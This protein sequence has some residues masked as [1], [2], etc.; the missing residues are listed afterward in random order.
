M[1]LI[2]R[3]DQL[4]IL[5]EYLGDAVAGSGRLVLLGG[6]AGVGKS[7]LLEHFVEDVSVRVATGGCDGLA[8]PR[9]L[10]PLMEI[11]D[12]LGLE[13]GTSRDEL[14]SAIVGAL[15]N[16]PTVVVI[17]DVHW[18]DGVTRDFVLFLGRRL[19]RL[20]ILAI[21]SYRDDEGGAD[22]PLRRMLGEA[23]RFSAARRLTLPRFTPQGVGALIEGSGLDPADVHALTGGNPYFVKEIVASGSLVPT[24]V[25]DAIVSRAAVLSRSARRALEVASQLGARFDAMLLADASEGDADGVDECLER[26]LLHLYGDRIGFS[27][28][29]ARAA[30]ESEL[31]PVRRIAIHR[32]VLR[33]LV[34]SG[35]DDVAA[36]AH[37]AA[38]AGDGDAAV[39]Y[40][41]PAAEQAS[42]LGAHTEARAQLAIALRY[43]GRLDDRSRA[44]L[45]DRLAWECQLIDRVDDALAAREEALSIW[46]RL[47]DTLGIGV[48]HRYLSRLRWYN[49]E[50]DLA[51]QHAKRSVEILESLPPTPELARAYGDISGIYMLRSRLEES[52]EFGTKA[53]ALGEELDAPKVVAHA[54]NNVGSVL[55]MAGR[56]EEGMEKLE[57]SLHLSLEGGWPD[58]VSRARINMASAAHANLELDR[59]GRLV[60]EGIAY[61]D[62]RD[63]VIFRVC[64]MGE[65]LEQAMTRGRWD[66]ALADAEDLMARSQTRKI[67]QSTALYAKAAIAVR[68]GEPDARAHVSAALEVLERS[69]ELQRFALVA[70]VHAEEAWLRNDAD[71][72]RGAVAHVW[73]IVSE[74]QAPVERGILASWLARVDALDEPLPSVSHPYDLQIEGRW[75]EAAEEWRRLGVPYQTG[76][77]LIETG[78]AAALTE[79]Y[80]IFDRLGAKPAAALAAARL[81]ELGERI[82]RPRR[83]TTREHP[84]GLTAREDEILALVAEGNTNSEIAAAL[85]ISEKTVEHHVSR[86]LTKLGASTRRDAARA[87]K[88]MGLALQ[89]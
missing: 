69:D 47:D 43:A 60:D 85:F 2:E 31:Q 25:R 51:E 33:A 36:L 87:A 1:E 75:A 77:A 27:H 81:R 71:G 15:A 57:R 53:I 61:A 20:K 22:D 52:V 34:E 66:E 26:R 24:T 56:Y 49:A 9:P 46:E 74:R 65:R 76:C 44:D 40:G 30:I 45:L 89:T 48:E 62:D 4:G 59:A 42:A 19:A 55:T 78:E 18:A 13:R 11:A 63:L 70:G 29:I 84:A 14:F 50:D 3:E 28:E 12:Q 68:R 17:E 39:R 73:E 6:E 64:L 80:E 86:V 72:V 41:I 32:S 35:S 82:P 5:S 21:V 38:G 79:A 83:V 16:Q 37:H 23:S 7:A 88:R 67:S 54:L 8:T 10:A 58:H